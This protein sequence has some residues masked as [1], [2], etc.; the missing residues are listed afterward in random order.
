ME[1]KFFANR[2]NLEHYTEWKRY[3]IHNL[4]FLA[5]AS[6]IFGNVVRKHWAPTGIRTRYLWTQGTLVNQATLPPPQPPARL[7][8]RFVSNPCRRRSSAPP[9]SMKAF[10]TDSPKTRSSIQDSNPGFL[11]KRQWRYWKAIVIKRLPPPLTSSG[12]S[13]I[14]LEGDQLLPSR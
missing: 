10:C 1:N 11:N 6:G 9:P 3:T 4:S 14:R 12:L 5:Y 2:S 13:T 7:A 8:N